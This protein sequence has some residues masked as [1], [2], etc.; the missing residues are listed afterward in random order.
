M[1]LLNKYNYNYN[2][3]GRKLYKPADWKKCM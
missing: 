3:Q 2:N 1:Y